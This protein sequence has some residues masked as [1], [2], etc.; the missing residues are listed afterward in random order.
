MKRLQE[1]L[2]NGDCLTHRNIMGGVLSSGEPC[3]P[4]HSNVT[5][6]SLYGALT[7]CYEDNVTPREVRNEAYFRLLAATPPRFHAR[8][9]PLMDY[10]TF[11]TT[12]EILQLVKDA[13]V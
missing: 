12:E 5:K 13:G 2:G 3:A 7:R 8:C 9:T 10:G 4:F 11:A 6:W 1:F